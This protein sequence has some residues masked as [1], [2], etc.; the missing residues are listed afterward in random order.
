[1]KKVASL[2]ILSVALA[3]SLSTFTAQADGRGPGDQ[4]IKQPQHQQ[5]PQ[6]QQ[7]SKHQQAPQH[8]QAPKHADNRQQN[9][10]HPQSRDHFT[11]SG[12]DFRKGKPVPQGFRADNYR[13]KDWRA[14][15]LYQPPRG[16]NWAYINGNY[17]LIAAATGIVTAILLESA[18]GH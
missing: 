13:V 6:H 4:P 11:W 2:L 16:Q 15:G 17:V 5:S 12:H 1:M 7:T 14:R 8:Q 3:G 10:K 9:V 18:N